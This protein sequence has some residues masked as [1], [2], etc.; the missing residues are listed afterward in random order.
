MCPNKGKKN[1]PWNLLRGQIIPLNEKVN[2]V[3]CWRLTL[4]SWWNNSL[5]V[6]LDQRV[7][8]LRATAHIWNTHQKANRSV[9]LYATDEEPEMCVF[10][11][12]C[13]QSSLFSTAVSHTSSL[14]AD[15]AALLWQHSKVQFQEKSSHT[16]AYT[17][18]HG[19]TI[20][21]QTHS[22]SGGFM[23]LFLNMVSVLN[24]HRSVTAVN[25]LAKWCLDV[26]LVKK[27]VNILRKV[28]IS[29]KRI[30]QMKAKIVIMQ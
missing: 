26:I 23:F 17:I 9:P 4:K 20:I 22:H 2:I 16:Q 6:L 21:R 3:H 12:T 18:T 1:M 29:Y 5:S 7:T 11:D 15:L 24:F 10:E 19:R 8:G 27:S 25:S 28:L 14:I 30:W 13:P